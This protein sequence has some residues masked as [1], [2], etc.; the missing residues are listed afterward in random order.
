[1]HFF[2]P[3]VELGIFGGFWAS[4]AAA[5]GASRARARTAMRN[6]RMR[7]RRLARDLHLDRVDGSRQR[8]PSSLR[9]NRC[10][11]PSDVGSSF[12]IRYH[13]AEL[14]HDVRS[15]RIVRQSFGP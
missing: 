2:V 15:S 13:A 7:R 10:G 9:R 14:S 8:S 5:V 4:W 3:F 1:M 11:H 6:A 12:V